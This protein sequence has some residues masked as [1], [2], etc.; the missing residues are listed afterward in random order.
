VP[1]IQDKRT[2]AGHNTAPTAQGS[3]VGEVD[4]GMQTVRQKAKRRHGAGCPWLVVAICLILA[5]GG[6]ADQKGGGLFER[7]YLF[8]EVPSRDLEIKGISIPLGIEKMPGGLVVFSCERAGV[9]SKSINGFRIGLIPQASLWGVEWRVRGDSLEADWCREILQFLQREPL[10][11]EGRIERFVLLF[12]A[13]PGFRLQAEEAAFADER[14][15]ELRQAR[16]EFDG[17]KFCIPRAVLF[18]N[19]PL[20][21]RLRLAEA[22]DTTDSI[23]IKIPSYSAELESWKCDPDLEPNRKYEQNTEVP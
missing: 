14:L 4:I 9:E 2:M 10:L 20:A 7:E 21:G 22:P 5:G 23:E 19:G 3:A 12:D 15:L 11:L 18:L 6:L 8:G 1:N 13:V 16:L 17:Q